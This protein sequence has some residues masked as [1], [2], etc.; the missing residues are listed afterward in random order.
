MELNTEV[1]VQVHGW[2]ML[3]G[4]KNRKYLIEK[5]KHGECFIYWFKIPRTKR[6]LFGHYANKVEMSIH[7][8]GR[9]DNFIE[10]LK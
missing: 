8:V 9:Q 2:I 5:V 4:V 7:P 1:L 10:I 3:K 6:K